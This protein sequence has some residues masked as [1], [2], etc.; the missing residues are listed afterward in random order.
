ME[1][2]ETRIEEGIQITCL[3]SHRKALEDLE[4][5]KLQYQKSEKRDVRTA[6]DCDKLVE[7]T[8]CPDYIP[9][10]IMEW[11]DTTTGY[12]IVWSNEMAEMS[13]IVKDKNA[14]K[15]QFEWIGLSCQDERG[16]YLSHLG[17]GED[18]T[19]RFKTML[20]LLR[21]MQLAI[22]ECIELAQKNEMG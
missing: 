7:D 8:S 17:V 10:D 13:Y 12:A 6:D 3:G 2:G 22:N 19:L 15:P 4:D 5:W 1:I 16:F 20:D 21:S 14:K 11:K 9:T 18:G